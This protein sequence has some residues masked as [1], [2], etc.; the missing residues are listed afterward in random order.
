MNLLYDVSFNREVGQ[1]GAL[2]W[3]LEE[4]NL[5][6]LINKADKLSED[7]IEVLDNKSFE[8]VKNNYSWEYIA[9]EYLKVF[10]KD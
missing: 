6:N 9:S 4:D 7:N 1:D 8:R 10:L 5:S 2:Y 3:N